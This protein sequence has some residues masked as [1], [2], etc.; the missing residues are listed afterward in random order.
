MMRRSYRKKIYHFLRIIKSSLTKHFSMWVSTQLIF[1]SLFGES[2]TAVCVA[3]FVFGREDEEES[4]VSEYHGCKIDTKNL[5]AFLQTQCTSEQVMQIRSSP[6]FSEHAVALRLLA[7]GDNIWSPC[8]PPALMS[9]CNLYRTRYAALPTNSQFTERGV[10][11]SGY[12]S[13][14]RRSEKN[15]SILATARARLIPDAMAEGKKKINKNDGKKKLVQGKVRAQ[16]LL[17]EAI[18]HQ[19][20]LDNLRTRNPSEYDQTYQSV[21]KRLSCEDMQFKK[22]RIEEKVR[23]YKEKENTTT[24]RGQRQ[25]QEQKK[26]DLTP[27]LEGKIQ[28][29]KMKRDHNI[30]QIQRE[31]K[32][33]NLRYEANTNWTTLIQLIKADEK[34]NKYFKPKTDYDLFKWNETHYD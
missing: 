28:Y 20:E 16:V 14:G 24:R 22:E 29:G 3:K 34:D 8:A 31:C 26:Y 7:D 6:F 18:K 21:A 32:A 27:L 19:Q 33:R 25:Q 9:F 4:Y 23:N 15:R 17:E 12:V 10:K 13:L 11:E 2:K 30:D 5:R 1:L